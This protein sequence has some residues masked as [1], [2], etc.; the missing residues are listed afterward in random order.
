MLKYQ[1]AGL[2]GY[3]S[4]AQEALKDTFYLKIYLHTYLYIYKTTSLTDFQDFRCF[5]I[6]RSN[7]A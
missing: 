2:R 4:E 1:L 6:E 7:T 5:H 3:V